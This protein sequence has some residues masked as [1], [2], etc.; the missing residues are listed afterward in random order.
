M[1]AQDISEVF[2]RHYVPA[3]ADQVELFTLKQQYIFAVLV[4]KL[5][6]D[7]SKALVQQYE[8]DSDA[9]SIYRELVEIATASA[10]ANIEAVELSQRSG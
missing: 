7:E 2:D 9:H 5:L 8:A 3:N 1:K 4:A 6:A 10:G